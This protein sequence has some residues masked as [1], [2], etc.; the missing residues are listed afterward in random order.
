[1]KVNTSEEDGQGV[2]RFTAQQCHFT[3]SSDEE[4]QDATSDIVINFGVMN[5]SLAK[6]ISKMVSVDDILI[7]F[8]KQPSEKIVLGLLIHL[9]HVVILN[10]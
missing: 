4:M 5:T 9:T 7:Q 10:I 8:K 2:A 3:C 6:I 1:M